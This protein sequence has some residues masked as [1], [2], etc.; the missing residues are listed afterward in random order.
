M[1]ARTADSLGTHCLAHAVQGKGWQ[2]LW[3]HGS[4]K[5]HCGSWHTPFPRAM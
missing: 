3:G 1:P 2:A 4:Q 5:G